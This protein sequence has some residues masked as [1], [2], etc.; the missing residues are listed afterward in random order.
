MSAHRQSHKA[1]RHKSQQMVQIV[2]QLRDRFLADLKIGQ[3]V[4]Y[5]CR[6]FLVSIGAVP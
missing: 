6:V 5:V 1:T 4:S 2:Q 3:S